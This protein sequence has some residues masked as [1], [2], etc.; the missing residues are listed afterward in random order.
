VKCCKLVLILSVLAF[1]FSENVHATDYFICDCATGADPNCIVGNDSNSGL[2]P[3]SPWQSTSMAGSVITTLQA[4]DQI[5]FAK[6]GSW[7]NAA[8]GNLYNFNSTG[9]NPIVFDSYSPSWGGSAKPILSEATVDVNLFNFADDGDA[10]HDEGYVV[11]N[12]DLRGNGTAQ[13]AV[14]AYNDADYIHL[15]NLDI[16]GF[17]IGVHCAGANPPN[18][19]A[20]YQ[21]QHMTLLNSTIIDC[22]GQGFLGG[23]DYLRIEGCHFENNGFAQAIFN[24]NIYLS[25]GDHVVILNNELY[26][27]AIVDGMAHGTSLVVHG[28]LD[29]LLIEGNYVHEDAGFV[30][31]HAWGIAVDPGYASAESFTNVIIRGNLL[32]NM[33]N[34][35]IGVTS[36]PGAIIENNV[37]INESSGDLVAIAA[38]DRLRGDN[39][40]ETTNVTVRNN[41]IYLRNANV[42]TVGISVGDEGNGHVVASNVISLDGGN[43]FEMNLSD[44]DYASVDYNMMELLNNAKWGAGQDLSSWSLSRG[45]DLQSLTGDPQFTSPGAP[46][47]NLIPLSSSLLID[48][49]HPTLSSSID[50]TGA[51]RNGVADI[52]AYEIIIVN[53]SDSPKRIDGNNLSLYPNPTT[54]QI[55]LISDISLVGT[56]YTVYNCMGQ[57]LLTGRV[58]S[59]KM[60]LELGNYSAGIYYIVL[61]VD[62]VIKVIKE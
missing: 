58:A 61:G 11:R 42:F 15:E 60:V 18:P 37:I 32:V 36:A 25:N 12:L 19:G 33:F 38:P 16:Q 1:L 34:I 44:A 28:T 35:G 49:G 45:F 5:L 47:H 59:G 7:T 57:A 8:M 2:S 40:A 52:G 50:Y 4:G 9:S 51:P 6:G 46:D 31:G 26:R 24:H 22:S 55:K 3:A 39:D 48:A 20:D 21:N 56:A 30:T 54:G 27:S 17:E 41:S 29:D 10:D 43:G 23:A 62:Q 14:F 13:W 53:I